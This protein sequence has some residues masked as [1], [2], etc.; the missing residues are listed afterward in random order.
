VSAYFDQSFPREL[1]ASK[2]Q[3]GR[4]LLNSSIVLI[5]CTNEPFNAS[6]GSLLVDFVL[7]L[8]R[9]HSRPADPSGTVNKDR[10]F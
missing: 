4:N 2:V 8:S 9:S 10:L 5:A 1:L 7:D 6:R 3:L